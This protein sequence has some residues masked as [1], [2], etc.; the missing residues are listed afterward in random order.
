[1]SSKIGNYIST[2]KEE[3]GTNESIHVKGNLQAIS[4]SYSFISFF[5]MLLAA[6]V[7]MVPGPNTNETPDWKR[8]S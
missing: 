6:S 3:Q 5:R 2:R 1:M 4:L 7:M 8:K